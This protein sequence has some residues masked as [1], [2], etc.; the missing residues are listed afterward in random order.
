[1]RGRGS[2]LFVH[3]NLSEAARIY[4]PTA[5]RSANTTTDNAIPRFDGTA[6]ALQASGITID[7]NDNL[8]VNGTAPMPR[9]H[10]F[11]LTLSNNATDA[12][13]DIDIA[14]GEAGA[15]TAPF[16][17][18]VQ[19]TAGLTKRLD[20]AWAVGD[21]NGGLDTGTIANT[22]YHVW[23][24]K[25]ADTGVVDALFSTS[26]TSPTMPD[27]A[28]TLKRRIGSVIRSGGAILAFFQDGDEFQLVNLAANRTTSHHGTTQFLQ[29]LT[30]PSGVRVRA[31]FMATSINNS[32]GANLAAVSTPLMWRSQR[33]TRPAFRCS[34][35]S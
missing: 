34:V 21:G 15:D 18:M 24:I 17:A 20:A 14:V 23:L 35:R 29:T 1:M 30:V 16:G 10:I 33:P 31:N 22:T 8:T 28:C 6:G 27:A 3:I 13:N 12:T 19:S 11:G 26:A 32:A 9:G 5:R 4:A 7:D 2:K 25:R